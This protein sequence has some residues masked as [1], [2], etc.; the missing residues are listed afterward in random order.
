MTFDG[1]AVVYLLTTN[2]VSTFHDY[3]SDVFISSLQQLETLIPMS[4]AALKNQPGRN[5]VK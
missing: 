1:H 2:G 3:A 4:N 5:K